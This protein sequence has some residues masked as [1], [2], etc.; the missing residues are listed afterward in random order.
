MKENIEE[1][2]LQ[3]KETYG[4]FHGL[5]TISQ[6]LKSVMKD[7]ANWAKIRDLEK[8]SLEMIACKIARILNGDLCNADSWKDIAGYATLIMNTFA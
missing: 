2:L 1:L 6:K 3:R 7:S 4:E 8:E 5:A